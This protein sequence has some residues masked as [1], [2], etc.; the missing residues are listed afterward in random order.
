VLVNTV[1]HTWPFRWRFD[2]V[3]WTHRKRWVRD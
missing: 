1:H 3:G 2:L